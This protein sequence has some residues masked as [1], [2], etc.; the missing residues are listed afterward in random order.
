MPGR[1][2][3]GTGCVLLGCRG[4]TWTWKILSAASSY[5]S[6]LLSPRSAWDKRGLC[7]E[8]MLT[9]SWGGFPRSSRLGMGA[10][11]SLDRTCT[12]GWMPPSWLSLVLTGFVSSD[13]SSDHCDQE[14]QPLRAGLSPP[15]SSVAAP[16]PVLCKAWPGVE[17]PWHRL[18]LTLALRPPTLALGFL[19]STGPFFATER[20]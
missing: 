20:Q 11:P 10:G 5:H 17:Q 9:G 19:L 13:W 4:V 8:G 14:E 18:K 6:T 1:P 7:A 3:A 16:V 15:L 2:P 12:V